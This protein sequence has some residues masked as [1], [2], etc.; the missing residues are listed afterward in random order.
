MIYSINLSQLKQMKASV[1]IPMYNEWKYVGRCLESLATQ[2]I[3]DFEIILID[4]GSTDNSVTIAEQYAVKFKKFTL[5]H[6]QHWWPWK[7]RNWWATIAQ[8]DVLV[9]VDADMMFEKKYLNELMKPIIDGSEVG[10]SHGREYVANKDNKIARA[11]S[12][13]RSYYNPKITRWWIFRAVRKDK[14]LESGWFDVTKGYTDDNLSEKIWYSL[15]LS[16]PIAYH[17]NPESLWEIYSH[18]QRVGRSLWSSGEIV[19]YIKKYRIRVLLFVIWLVVMLF[20][21]WLIK[22]VV[23]WL[24]LL[25]WFC[26]YKG[27][28][29]AILER[30]ISHLLYIPIVMIVRGFG[31]VCGI[32]WYI[33]NK[34]IY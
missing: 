13:V 17:N 16:W 5:L 20:Q 12:L 23:W 21:V 14:F 28:Q 4:D 26:V 6:Q 32:L 22:W 11:F 27:I 24:S 31:Y 30:Y 7:A 3:N 8:W 33:L 2:N 10:T 29:R 1:I 34:Q 18:S 19:D 9:F 25:L 15:I